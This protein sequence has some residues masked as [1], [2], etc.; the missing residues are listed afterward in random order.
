MQ[1]ILDA[2]RANDMS[3]L[4]KIR[5]EAIAFGVI[6]DDEMDIDEDRPCV[7]PREVLD[8]RMMYSEDEI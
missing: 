3:K 4:R 5:E 1:Y 8:N 7:V 2:L 6:E